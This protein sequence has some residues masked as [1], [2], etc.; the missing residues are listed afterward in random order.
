MSFF[1]FADFVHRNTL[2]PVLRP[3]KNCGAL[4]LK[5]RWWKSFATNGLYF[6]NKLLFFY[7]LN[8]KCENF[9]ILD[10]MESYMHIDW[11]RDWNINTTCYLFQKYPFI[12]TCNCKV[13]A[14]SRL[15]IDAQVAL[16]CTYNFSLK[17]YWY[18]PVLYLTAGTDITV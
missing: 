1:F 4:F 18:Y 9:I 13:G 7:L 3:W 8:M 15:W 6:S 10:I 12:L 5:Q 11:Y 2:D 16:S 17:W 14:E